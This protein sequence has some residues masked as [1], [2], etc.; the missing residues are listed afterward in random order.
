VYEYCYLQMIFIHT[1]I[2]VAQH[3]AYQ[4]VFKLSSEGTVHY[5]YAAQGQTVNHF[6]LDVQSCLHDTVHCK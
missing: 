4:K 1:G 6:Y 2:E 5:K 3:Y